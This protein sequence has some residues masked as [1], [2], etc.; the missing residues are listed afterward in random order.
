MKNLTL[1]AVAGMFVATAPAFAQEDIKIGAIYMDAQGF[2]AGVRK[3]IQD[4]ANEANRELDVIET[5]A[6]GDVSKESS[7]IDSLISAGVEAIIVSPVSADGSFR[8]VRRAYDAGIPVVCYNTCLSE[9]DQQDFVSAYAVG[10]PYEFG[11]KLGEAAADYFVGAGIAAPKIAVLNCE[12]VE[13]CITRRKGFEDAL[14]AKVPDYEI[15]ANQE[16]AILDKA[17]SVASTILS[18]QPDLD[19]I[20][21]E[22][23]GATLGAARAVRSQ[24]RI[25]DVVVFGGDMTTEIARELEQ[26]DVIKAVVDISGQSMGRLAFAEAVQAISGDSDGEIKAPADID[27]YDTSEAGAAW[28]QAHPDGIP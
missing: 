9:A 7:F 28:L 26:F 19:A 17:V 12:F 21:G 27:L 1:A 20:F 11:A 25:G 23:G 16:G 4:A 10:D 13:V 6:Q 18:S 24:G 22:A 5:N 3:G 8:A 14:G 15:V 2:Y